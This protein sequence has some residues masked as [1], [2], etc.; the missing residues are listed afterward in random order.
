MRV[1]WVLRKDSW[2]TSLGATLGRAR[3]GAV[4]GALQARAGAATSALSE[5]SAVSCV[6][7]SAWG[8]LLGMNSSGRSLMSQSVLKAAAGLAAL[9]AI[10]FG[11]S[12]IASDS[13]SNTAALGGGPPGAGAQAGPPGQ[14]GAAPNGMPPAVAPPVGAPP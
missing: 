3:C 4:A 13:K 10:A 1:I 6:R 8:D 11:A 12:A 5:L 7:P 2:G 14:A 9:A